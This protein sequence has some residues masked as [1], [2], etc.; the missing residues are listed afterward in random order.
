MK[1]RTTETLRFGAATIIIHQ[2][3]LTD[4]ERTKREDQARTALSRVMRTYLKRK[5]HEHHE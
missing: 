4:Q 1:D 3:V 2:P 5:E